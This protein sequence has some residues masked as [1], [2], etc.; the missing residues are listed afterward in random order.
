ME[1]I[2]IW[3]CFAVGA[4]IIASNKGYNKTLAAVLGFF[5]GPLGCL[6]V[7]VS[8]G[9]RASADEARMRK[10]GMKKCPDCAELIRREAIKC[11]YCGKE[12]S[13]QVDVAISTPTP[14]QVDK[15]FPP[16]P[17]KVQPF[18]MTAPVAALAFMVLLGLVMNNC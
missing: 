14:P 3:M 8:D 4:T 18:S 12:F 15:T 9:D 6:I 17:Q 10:Q 1:Y 5:L 11:R 16:P 7:A 13:T 2:L